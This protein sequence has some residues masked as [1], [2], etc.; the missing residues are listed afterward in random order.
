MEKYTIDYCK[1]NK[2]AIHL[3][4]ECEAAAVIKLLNDNKVYWQYF[5][6]GNTRF[7]HYKEKTCYSLIDGLMIADVEHYQGDGFEI[8]TAHQF[9]QDNTPR[10][11]TEDEVLEHAKKAFE[12]GADYEYSSFDDYKKTLNLK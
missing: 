10:L 2:V 4:N 3:Q 11:Y 1:N 5:P 6:S 7:H 9:I 12:A 8:I